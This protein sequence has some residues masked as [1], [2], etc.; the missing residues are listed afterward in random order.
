[1]LHL[2]GCYT[3]ERADLSD[4][5]CTGLQL[6]NFWQD[7]AR[8]R[9]I[10]RVYLPAGDRHRF[11]YPDADLDAGRFTP[12]FAELIRFEVERTR[13]LFDR[14]DALLP[15]LP[16]AARLNVAPFAL[17]RFVSGALVDEHGAA[18]VAH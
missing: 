1:M 14:G 5:I 12:A 3:P 16:T 15:M 11:G 7:V 10:G 17:D 13:E 2:H 9:A 6:A 8:D 18:A 4:A